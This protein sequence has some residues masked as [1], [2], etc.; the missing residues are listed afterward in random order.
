M[1]LLF[2]EPFFGGSHRTFAE[3]LQSHSSHDIDL[4]T[5]PDRNWTWRMH[6]SALFFAEK[7]RPAGDYDGIIT[8]NMLRLADLK[9]FAGQRLPPVMVYFHESQ[10]TYPP[11]PGEKMDTGLAMSDISTALLADKILFNSQFHQTSFI[12]AIAEFMDRMPDCPIPGIEDKILVKSDVMYPGLDFSSDTNKHGMVRNKPLIIWNHRWSYDKNAP[13]FFYALDAMIKRGLEF[14]VALLGECPGWIPGEFEEAKD[15]LGKRVVQYGFLENK[16]DYINWLKQGSLALSTARQE[17][18]GMS[19]VE[20]VK[21]GCIPLLP[22]RLS[23]PEILPEEFHQDFLYSNQ[24]QFLDKLEKLLITWN[25]WEHIQCDLSH[26]MD[27]FSWE[28]IIDDYDH[29]LEGLCRQKTP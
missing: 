3:G 21:Y 26:A 20:A 24:K 2:I 12:T 4:L 18:F 19:M 1:K 27:R 23:Y 11:A 28:Y 7:L 14:E 25:T 16:N 8:S 22:H 10:L 13:S 6:G 17:N 5:L 9:A 15:R 29:V